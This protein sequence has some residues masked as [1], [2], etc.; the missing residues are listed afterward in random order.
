MVSRRRKSKPT[1]RQKPAPL[2][3]WTRELVVPIL[4][5]ALGTVMV[6]G[7]TWVAVRAGVPWAP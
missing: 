7:L 2:P 4:G 6:A 5:K 3:F 1:P